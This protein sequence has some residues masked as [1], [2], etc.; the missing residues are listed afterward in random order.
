LAGQNLVAPVLP[1]EAIDMYRKDIHL[2]GRVIDSTLSAIQKDIKISSQPRFGFTA[3]D[4][5]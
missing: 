1:E 4:P 3:Q 5:F 2:T